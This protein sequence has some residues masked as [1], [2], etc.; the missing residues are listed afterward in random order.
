MELALHKPLLTSNREAE[1]SVN[2]KFS[3]ICSQSLQQGPGVGPL[4][5]TWWWI[6]D[7]FGVILCFPSNACVTDATSQSIGR[8]TTTLDVNHGPM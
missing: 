7:Q 2:V 3:S 6:L 1:L 8:S 5:L 4:S